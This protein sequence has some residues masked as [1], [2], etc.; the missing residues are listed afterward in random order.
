MTT[1]ATSKS[2]TVTTR[3]PPFRADHVGSLLR[4]PRLKEARERLLGPHTADTNVAP[5][6]NDALRQI[7]D[8]FVREVIAMQERVGLKAIT[9][10]ELRRRSFMLELLLGWEGIAASRSD[11]SNLKWRNDT[12]ASDNMTSLSIVAPIRW[13]ESSTLA[14]F[15]F[16]KASTSGIPKLAL[17]APNLVHY[18]LSDAGRLDNTPYRD[19]EAFWADL[20]ATYI[21]EIK[22]LVTAGT[23]YIQF[24]DV[25]FG[26][27]CDPAH[28]DYMKRRGDDPDKLL[29]KY[30]STINAVIRDVPSNV[31]VTVHTCR[32]NREGQWFAEGSYEAVADIMF[33]QINVSGF[34]LEYDSA[35]AGGFGPLRF[36]PKDKTVVLGLVSTKK[37]ELES[38]EV[39]MNRID[40]ASKVVPL[41]QL[42][43]SPQCGFASS[44]R[45]NALTLAEQEAK[46]RRVV[47]VADKVW[48]DV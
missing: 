30:A 41:G 39:L 1:H 25:C 4:P 47:E 38:A 24:D 26:Y 9:D 35:R 23:T 18:F 5:H 36:L 14:H 28:R 22:S 48:G 16:L 43:L 3:Q 17:P 15:K 8:G 46:L 21:Q 42:A 37:P 34:F 27:M 12:G 13:R 45:G 32:G 29:E 6:H 11:S 31:T 44:Y 33:N 2:A 40:E 20:I 19:M 10:G 7:E